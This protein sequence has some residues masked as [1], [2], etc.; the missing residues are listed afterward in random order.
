MARHAFDA[1]ESN[2]LLS[3]PPV[4]PSNTARG[5]KPVMDWL[6]VRLAVALDVCD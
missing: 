5:K 6:A 1:I 3:T 2:T 4:V